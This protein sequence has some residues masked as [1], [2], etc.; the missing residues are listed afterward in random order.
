MSGRNMN[1][2]VMVR[3]RDQLTGPLR[4][5]RD[6]LKSLTDFS[7]KLG[8]LGAA[9]AAI[10]FMGPI[11]EAAAFQ[12]KLLDIAGTADLTGVKAFKLTDELRGKFE[13]LAFK[14]GQSSDMISQAFG[15]MMAAGLDRGKI[16]AS[17]FGIA[18][19]TTA[20]N[21]EMKDMAGVATSM[22][23]TLDMPVNQLEDAMAA[24]VVSGRLG[25]FE[26][27]DMAKVFPSLTSSMVQYGIKGREAV[28]FLGTALQIARKGT[29]APDEAANNLKN[30]LD[31]LKM[32]E[33]LRNFKKAG[34]DLEAV[35]SDAVV[36]GINPIEAVIR[37]VADLS[38]VTGDQ[39]AG[40]MKKAE[41]N[42]LK[43]ADALASVREQLE[44]IKGASKLGELF[45]D[46]QVMNFLIPAL[47][48]IDE[49]KTISAEVRKATAKMIDPAFETQ[50]QGLNI[51]LGIFREIGT[52]ASREVGFAFGT[53]LPDINKS[54][55]DGIVWWREWNKESGGLGTKML[56]FGG[57]AILAA[58]AI[59]ALG[60]VL[61]AVAAGL[62]ALAAILSP[63]GIAIAAVAAGGVYLWRNWGTYGPRVMKMWEGAKRGF[64]DFADG[65]RD[66][67]GRVVKAG[68]YIAS[69]F[70]ARLFSGLSSAWEDL[71]GGWDNVKGFFNDIRK[72]ADIK[73]NWSGFTIDDVTVTA[74]KTIAIAMRGIRVGWDAL[75]SFGSGFAP[76]LKEIGESIGGSVKAFKDVG[77]GL[78]RI[79]AAFGKLTNFDSGRLNNVFSV[80]GDIAGRISKWQ[81]GKLEQAANAVSTLVKGIAW[82][83]EKVASIK[84]PW[85]NLSPAG[86]LIDQWKTIANA[87]NT[88]KAALDAWKTPSPQVK[89][90]AQKT[91]NVIN[92]EQARASKTIGRGRLIPGT[93]DNILGKAQDDRD[94]GRTMPLISKDGGALNALVSAVR[95][96]ANVVLPAQK[97]DVNVKVEGPGTVTG[98][99]VSKQA[100]GRVVGEP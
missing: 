44:K 7:R 29:S 23:Q 99:T 27:K 30:F 45:G 20:V 4:R 85:E 59:G 13:A 16:E 17:M 74:I 75:K 33:T 62:G 93:T 35:M 41:A 46:Q 48:N 57:G 9:I 38:G 96:L 1:L 32:P 21:A 25:S 28:D 3:L 51:Q 78:W 39:L 88:V 36:Q 2:D 40:M 8:V 86:F 60:F 90:L 63:V 89:E 54:L 66:G 61:P 69:L 11:K 37:K 24:L 34:V 79:G 55:M 73:F 68:R 72:A 18:K 22:L 100:T 80:L 6:Q 97:V 12:Q 95:N 26:L 52:Q 98:K 50:M 76:H 43:G 84:I 91:G 47:A 67:V 77:D 64:W 83:A 49:W 65:V 87:I 15:D 94:M 31:K 58:T 14:T 19:A 81:F 82:L 92:F 5:V 42:G 10:S 56:T 71:K 53:L 70:D